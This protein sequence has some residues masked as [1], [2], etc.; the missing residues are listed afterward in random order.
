MATTP[1]TPRRHFAPL[2]HL[3]A[4]ALTRTGLAEKMGVTAHHAG[5]LI[6]E[7]EKLKLVRVIGTVPATGRGSGPAQWLWTAQPLTAPSNSSPTT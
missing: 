1:R 6:R 5:M 3:K 4:E 7:L 2:T